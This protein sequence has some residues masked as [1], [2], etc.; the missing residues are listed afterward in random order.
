MTR[1]LDD[2]LQVS[3]A[4]TEVTVVA[5]AVQLATPETAAVAR[6]LSAE[7]LVAVPTPTRSFT[8]LLSA[9]AGVSCGSIT[10]VDKRRLEIY[11]RL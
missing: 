11:H 4:Q 1:T 3:T 7:Q 6:Q 9:E 10:G 5:D 8:H 2:K